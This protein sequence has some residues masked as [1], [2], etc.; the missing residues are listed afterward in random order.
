MCSLLDLPGLPNA[1]KR[2]AMVHGH[3][4]KK[5]KRKK[6]SSLRLIYH[7]GCPGRWDEHGLSSRSP[8]VE[9]W[10]RALVMLLNLS[11][12]GSPINTV[13][14]ITAVTVK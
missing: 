3:F 10:S 12:L 1:K 5:K 14:M 8:G 6:K 7:P 2:E 9:S 13:G 11:K 4:P